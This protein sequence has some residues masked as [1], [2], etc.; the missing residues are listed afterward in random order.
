VDYTELELIVPVA[1]AMALGGLIGAEREW[2]NKPA[3]FRTHMLVAGAAAL[4]VGLGD[5]LLDHFVTSGE[6]IQADPLRVVEAIITG[7][8]FIGAGT[9]IRRDGRHPVEGLT[10]AASFLLSA[11]IGIACAVQAYLLAAVVT[12]LTL[13]VL[14]VMGYFEPRIRAHGK[15]RDH[16]D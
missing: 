1:L 11:A 9:I 8:S 3:G 14:R 16:P 6:A 13:V 4:L 2:A 15:G 5:L 7:L 10:T 12:L